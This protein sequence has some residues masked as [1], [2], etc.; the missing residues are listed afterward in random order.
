MFDTDDV[1]AETEETITVGAAEIMAKMT[2]PGLVAS[3]CK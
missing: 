1:D 2:K 3:T